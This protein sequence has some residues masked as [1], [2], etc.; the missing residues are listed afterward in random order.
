MLRRQ[1]ADKAAAEHHGSEPDR[2]GLDPLPASDRPHAALLPAA[3]TALARAF[4]ILRE[5][6]CLVEKP[7]TSLP[8]GVAAGGAVRKEDHAGSVTAPRLQRPVCLW[9]QPVGCR[10]YL[11]R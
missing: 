1:H 9:R 10:Q 7:T 2:H 5:A 3:V 4:N 11:N 6:F 8:G